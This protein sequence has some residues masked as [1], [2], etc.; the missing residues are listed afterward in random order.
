[1]KELE[2]WFHSEYYHSLTNVD[3]DWLIKNLK[4]RE[5]ER[6][7]TVYNK[8]LSTINTSQIKLVVHTP[9]GEDNIN[10]LIPPRLFEAFQK[11]IVAQKKELEK[12]LKEVKERE[13]A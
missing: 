5:L 4:I 12:E 11:V 6:V 3:G 10:F 7:I 9:Q 13:C 2:S 8:A 1:M